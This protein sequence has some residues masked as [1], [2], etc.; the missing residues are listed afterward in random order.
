M[1]N[2]AHNYEYVFKTVLDV[3]NGKNGWYSP[4]THIKSLLPADNKLPMVDMIYYINLDKRVDRNTHMLE[5]FKKCNIPNNMIKRFRAIDGNNYK[6]KES[7]LALFKNADFIKWPCAKKIMGNQLSHF[8]IYKNMLDNNY[9]NVLIL[10]DDVVFRENF[11][12]HLNNLIL[13]LPS[14]CEIANIGMHEY[15]KFDKFQ[16]YDLTRVDHDVRVEKIKIS[17]N[18]CILKD[19]MQP[20]SLS[21]VITQ[22]GAKNIISH[23]EKN[24]FPYATD[25]S[26][27]RYL[28]AKKI[29][30]GSRIILCT[31]NPSFGSDIFGPTLPI[32]NIKKM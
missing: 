11:V 32:P 30:Y 25:I 3:F 9:K 16:A 4:D 2:L 18:I 28:I 10:Q 23:F 26:L 14:D 20:C 17:N 12:S 24:G 1:Y 29:F 21:Y 6:F 15:A 31:G 19:N 27:N 22:N 13:E 5:Q 7:E 8:S